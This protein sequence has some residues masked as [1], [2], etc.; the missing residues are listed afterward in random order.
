MAIEVTVVDGLGDVLGD[1]GSPIPTTDA[2]P[3]QTITRT[4]T[5]SA[6]M[7][8]AA[9]ITVAPTSSQ[10]ILAMDVVVSTDTAMNFSIQEETSATVFAK[11]FM[12]ANG[13]VQITPRGYLKAAVADKKLQ[14]KASVAGNVGI[15]VIYTSEA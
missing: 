8:S 6:D 14:G 3:L 11:V 9:D 5:A 2:G 10:K 1:S 15:T 7:T 4:Y 12:P 13:S